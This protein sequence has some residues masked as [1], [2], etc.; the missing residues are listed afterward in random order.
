MKRFDQVNVIPFIDIMLVLLAIVLT[1]ATFISQEKIALELPK[2][3]NIISDTHKIAVKIAI[4]HSG[5][6]YLDEKPV[7]FT[8]LSRALRS[9]TKDDTILLYVDKSVRFELFIQIIDSLK[10]NQLENLSIMTRKAHE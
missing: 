4:D 7:D 10:Q 5:M 2:A 9:L 3:E 8:V 6:Y 1:T